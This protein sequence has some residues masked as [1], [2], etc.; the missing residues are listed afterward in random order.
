M[1]IPQ[2]CSSCSLPSQEIS[3]DPS[4][5]MSSP[6]VHYQSSSDDFPPSS[7]DTAFHGSAG[8]TLWVSVSVLKKMGKRVSKCLKS[9][10][11]CFTATEGAVSSRKGS[12]R[13]GR[14]LPID[15]R[16]IGL[17]IVI[18]SPFVDRPV[19]ERKVVGVVIGLEKPSCMSA[20][21]PLKVAF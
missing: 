19:D 1:G 9:R 17:D 7:I 21:I 2:E 11:Q 5:P 6:P 12:N 16:T 10:R 13:C 14:V 18:E 4:T 8:R 20:C 3:I 15:L